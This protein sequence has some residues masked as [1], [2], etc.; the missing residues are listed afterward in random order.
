V[1]LFFEYTFVIIFM[2][3]IINMKTKRAA[4][5]V[6]SQFNKHKRAPD[7]KIKATTRLLVLAI[8][9]TILLSAI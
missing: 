3:G 9:H 8:L 2:A 7:K 1:G 6:G 5:E 4:H